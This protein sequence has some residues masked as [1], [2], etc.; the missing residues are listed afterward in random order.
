MMVCQAHHLATNSH[1][2]GIKFGNKSMF[3]ECSHVAYQIK[4]NEM[5]DNIQANILTLRTPWTP[6]LGSIDQ[7]SFFFLKVVAAY[8]IKGNDAY[9]NMEAKSLHLY[10]HS[11][12]GMGSK[13]E[14]LFFFFRIWSNYISN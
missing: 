14:N 5:Y 4:G 9:N 11:S 8:Q 6:G 7:N 3:S 10:T 2:Q 1:G 13:G 12:P